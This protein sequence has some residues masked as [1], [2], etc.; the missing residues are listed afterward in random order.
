MFLVG[1]YQEI[2][3]DL[4][5]LFGD[6]DSVHVELTP[7]GGHKLVAPRRGDSV[8]SVLR[9]VHFDPDD[10]LAAYRQ[11]VNHATWLDTRQSET[12]LAELAAGLEGY[13]YLEE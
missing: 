11:K 5:N 9:F 4:H 2:L 7:D 6:T 12:Y 1:A 10:L 3:G 13:T 8:S